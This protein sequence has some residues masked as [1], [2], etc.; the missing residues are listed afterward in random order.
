MVLDVTY[1]GLSALVD[2]HVFD[3]DLLLPLSTVPIE[4]LQQSRVSPGKPVSLIEILPATFE[5]LLPNH[6]ASV[7]FH[8]RIM[9]RDKLCRDHSLN[10]VLGRNGD[11][12]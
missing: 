1:D 2:M 6:S 7:T 10:F 4:G 8:R 12:R 11:Q 5:A 3:C 9:R